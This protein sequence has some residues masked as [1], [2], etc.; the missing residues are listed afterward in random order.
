M[1]APSQ[2]LHRGQ[3]RAWSR[4]DRPSLSPSPL[5]AIADGFEATRE[6]FR[7]CLPHALQQLDCS[8]IG[9]RSLFPQLRP[10]RQRHPLG[11]IAPGIVAANMPHQFINKVLGERWKEAS[12]VPRDENPATDRRATV[13]NRHSFHTVARNTDVRRHN[14]C[15]IAAP[16]EVR[17]RLFWP[18]RLNRRGPLCLSSQKPRVDSDAMQASEK[19]QQ[20]RLCAAAIRRAYRVLDLLA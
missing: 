6:S 15:T 18:R 5:P 2:G 17:A 1:G 16:G 9:R 20:E 3:S 14:G 11:D 7:L 4:R 19:P 12:A 10:L 8:Q 13:S